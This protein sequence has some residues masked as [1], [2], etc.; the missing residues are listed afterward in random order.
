[1]GEAPLTVHETREF[2]PGK[3]NRPL[4]QEIAEKTGGEFVPGLANN[5]A[6][7]FEGQGATR[8]F[9]PLWPYVA[10]FALFLYLID[11]YL[12]KAGVFAVSSQTEIEDA[13]GV[14]TPDMYMQLATKF[15]N[16]AEEHSLKGEVDEA[17]R[18]FLRA[19]AFFLKAQATKEANVMWERYKRFESR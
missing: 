3:A 14:A 2:M 7:A 12:R 9:F 13:G 5:L 6:I 11:I 18:Y 10:F 8:I 15:S 19:K 16:M 17:K 1:V 4:L